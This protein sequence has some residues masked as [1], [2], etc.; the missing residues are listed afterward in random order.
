MLT[1][2]KPNVKS[3]WEGCDAA[4]NGPP[5]LDWILLERGRE[6]AP[7]LKSLGAKD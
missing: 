6:L 3:R 5:R 2:G 1:R 4:A 7:A